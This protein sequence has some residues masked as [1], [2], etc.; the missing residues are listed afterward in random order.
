M[1]R[2]PVLVD[3]RPTCPWCN[4]PAPTP[5]I[6]VPD[7]TPA[8]APTPPPAPAP[9][10]SPESA[11]PPGTPAAPP[12]APSTPPAKPPQLAP[13]AFEL[14]PGVVLGGFEIVRLLARGGTSHVYL[15]KQLSLQ[16]D[17]ALK[18]MWQYT[19]AEGVLKRF[20]RE[21]RATASLE[22]PNIISLYEAGQEQGVCYLAMTYVDGQSL[23]QL[24][25]A[26]QS[27]L[28]ERTALGIVRQVAAALRHA[29]DR[30]QLLH[31]DLKP[32]NIMVDR[33]GRVRL[34]D[35]GIAARA[36]E[37]AGS[38]TVQGLILGT[39]NYLSPEQ[40]RGAAD[41]DFRTDIYSLGAT[42]F[43]LVTNSPPFHGETIHQLLMQHVLAPV[44]S[45]RA[46]NAAVSPAADALI[47][48]MLAKAPADRFA[49]WD[50][51][52]AAINQVLGEPEQEPG[53]GTT[54]GHAVVGAAAL[55][56]GT[57]EAAQVGADATP[58]VGVPA[59]PGAAPDSDDG[60]AA[61]PARETTS[62]A[63]LAL[64]LGVLV[65][66]VLALLAGIWL[67]PPGPAHGTAPPP[68]VPP[69][70]QPVMVAPASPTVPG[71]VAVVPGTTTN[72]GSGDLAAEVAAAVATAVQAGQS[73]LLLADRYQAAGDL[74]RARLAWWLCLREYPG[75][76][77]QWAQTA[78]EH[79]AA[80]ATASQDAVEAEAVWRAAYTATAK[81][82]PDLATPWL[83]AGVT[84]MTSP[85]R[86]RDRERWLWSPLEQNPDGHWQLAGVAAQRLLQQYRQMDARESTRVV[87]QYCLDKFPA[88]H[89]VRTEAQAALRALDPAAAATV[90]GTAAAPVKPATAAVD[91]QVAALTK[92]L[93]AQ[94]DPL[95]R[96]RY[97]LRLGDVLQAAQRWTEAEPYYARA[98][99]E[100]GEQGGGSVGGPALLALA[101][102]QTAR[103]DALGAA[104]TLEG[105][106]ANAKLQG[107]DGE[108][109]LAAAKQL[110]DH[111]TRTKENV[112]QSLALQAI[113]DRFPGAHGK[114]AA[115]AG[116]QLAALHEQ[117]KHWALALTTWRQVIQKCDGVTYAEASH[118]AA[119]MRRL[120]A[121][122]ATELL[123]TAPPPLLVLPEPFPT[124][125][126]L[127][128]DL[129]EIAVAERDNTLAAATALTVEAWLLPAP[130]GGKQQVLVSRHD[131]EK[132]GFTLLLTDRQLQWQLADGTRT[133]TLT[134]PAAL[135]ADQWV[136]VAATVR[137]GEAQLFV[138]GVRVAQS[139]DVAVDNHDAGQL[140]VGRG[141][142]ADARPYRGALQHVVVTPA[143][144]Y[145]APFTPAAE[146]LP[147]TANSAAV[148]LRWRQLK[149]DDACGNRLQLLTK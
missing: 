144:R 123:G 63:F 11:A 121:A 136:H 128:D 124:A 139:S 68:T 27:P 58:V 35:L 50:E 138:N 117:K 18:V 6:P 122:H 142:R 76:R 61:A 7:A 21:I 56:V 140:R 26:R 55:A 62:P 3:N 45:A 53:M 83:L 9:A 80:R 25:A 66:T 74:P 107:T 41:L 110:V 13:P 15:A 114:E 72:A 100:F 23:E 39:P 120:Q 52:I 78:A 12:A 105:L 32:G 104:L 137:K 108:Y 133:W 60:T 143:V 8:P 37:G 146:P 30:Q 57:L 2:E 24:L 43:H 115:T 82:R 96:G 47:M 113:V 75:P 95:A 49:T 33:L 31:R 28:P 44:P 102:G 81:A 116:R 111:Y 17:V 119:E 103:G 48:R 92:E 34:L 109:G 89:P 91:E 46:T 132:R 94:T 4:A 127:G 141:V 64:L 54:G 5:D 40:A 71:S 73:P 101:K 87:A 19:D 86:A 118:A 134:S 135:P 99:K 14:H 106:L 70:E 36:A 112:P 90:P 88:G 1:A 126:L 20:R 130:D 42:L 22:H 148:W 147:A 98:A 29:W 67:V 77:C 51:L 131:A 97:L 129:K 65:I 59:V 125:M 10:R 93:A 16:R 145:D 149:V 69:E 79:L 85:D 84:A 38:I